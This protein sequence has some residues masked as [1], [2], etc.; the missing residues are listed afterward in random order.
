MEYTL[1]KKIIEAIFIIEICMLPFVN[2]YLGV[3]CVFI[4]G[5]SILFLKKNNPNYF[6]FKKGD[7]VII[8]FYPYVSSGTV[9][10]N[11]V[12]CERKSC[13][14]KW[15]EKNPV[16]HKNTGTYLE[17]HLI[18]ANQDKAALLSAIDNVK[19]D[20][21]NKFNEIDRLEYIKDALDTSKWSKEKKDY[22]LAVWSG[23][24]M[25]S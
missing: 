14:V 18:D 2:I 15:D 11:V 3:G 8:V 9:L 7:R 16:L 4:V 21:Q 25:G 19:M 12:V 20:A 13:V 5:M 6:K 23:G 10:K 22:T 1:A 17:E 24:V